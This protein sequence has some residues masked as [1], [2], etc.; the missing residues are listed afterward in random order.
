MARPIDRTIV[1]GQRGNFISVPTDCPQ[2]DERLGWLGDAQVFARTACYNRDV[3]AFFTNGWTTSSTPSCPPAPSPT[4]RRGSPSR[5]AGAPAWGDAGVIVPWTMWKIYGDTAVLD[6]HFGAMTRW[7]DFLQRANPDYLWARELG[8][9]YGDWL[10]PGGDTPRTICSPPPTGRTTPRSMAEIADAT[11]RPDDAAGYRA[12][13]A[14]I[15]SAF[16]DAFVAADGQVT[17]GTQTA[18]VSPCTWT[19]SPTPAGRRGGAPRGGDQRRGLAPDHRLRRRRVLL[20]VLSATGHSAAAYR[21]L[22]RT[23]SRRGAT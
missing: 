16:T 18:Y 12:L 20:P 6:R 22:E 8:N 1:W 11:G 2:R 23:P 9:S 17:S 10:A 13:R 21:L 14:K 5:G 19:C 3:A 4:S 15:R 7:M